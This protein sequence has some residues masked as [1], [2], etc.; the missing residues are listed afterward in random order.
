MFEPVV[1]ASNDP[2]RVR[3]TFGSLAV[4]TVAV[5]VWRQ[6]DVLLPVPGTVR[7]AAAG[8]FTVV[9]YWV[10]HSVEVSY[11][12]EMFDVSGVSLGVSG[13]TSVTVWGDRQAVWVSDPFDPSMVVQV[14]M[15]VSFGA[16]LK[17]GHP[18]SRYNVGGRVV[19][20]VGEVGLFE[21]VDFSLKTDT[22]AQ[23]DALKRVLDGR[24]VLFR[25]APFVRPQF[26][27]LLYA[28]VSYSIVDA[29]HLGGFQ[30]GGESASWVV[31]GD[32]VSPLTVGAA[33]AGATY[34]DYKAVFATYADAK[35]AYVTYLDAK[36]NPP[37]G[38]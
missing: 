32:Q 7:V 19:S 18:S 10:P 29:D 5:T 31:S 26:P 37:G 8:G 24:L 20:L 23:A 25:L 12:A 14:E 15:D 17:V 38:L 33:V 9:D 1:V 27:S 13:V 36:S 30:F 21:G 28:D 34:G 16:Q 4:G 3:V 11:F 6:A 35:A 22:Q 2:P